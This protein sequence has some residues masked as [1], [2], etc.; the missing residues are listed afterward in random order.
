MLQLTTWYFSLKYGEIS[1]I[2]WLENFLDLFSS[3]LSVRFVLGITLFILFGT[4][5][6]S[7]CTL[8]AVK[9]AVGASNNKPLTY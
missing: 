4:P 6:F 8:P 5:E 7:G 2:S 3:I 9:D 1:G